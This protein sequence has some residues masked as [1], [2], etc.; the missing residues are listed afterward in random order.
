MN[1]QTKPEELKE[2]PTVHF[3]ETQYGFEYGDVEITRVCS[4]GEKGWVLLG[5]KTSKY[6]HD[7][8]KKSEIQI[9]ITK[10]GKVRTFSDGE[11][12]APTHKEKGQY[13]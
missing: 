10:T 11:W 4:D 5:L 9:Y 2:V 3:K 6:K 12:I 7:G 8:T 13:K 1:R